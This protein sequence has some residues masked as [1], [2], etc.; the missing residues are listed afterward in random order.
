MDKIGQVRI[1]N[2]EGGHSVWVMIDGSGG[3]GEW[4]CVW[5]TAPGNLQ[6]DLPLGYIESRSEVVGAV[7][8]TPAANRDL[9]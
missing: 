6:A 8:G 3:L 4:L 2:H 9:K 1:E 5:S 7:P